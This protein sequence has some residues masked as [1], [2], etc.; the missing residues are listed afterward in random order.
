VYS[1]KAVDSRLERHLS[2]HKLHEERQSAC[3]QFHSTESALLCVQNDIL[4]SLG[5]NEATVLAMLD[6][7]AAFDTIDHKNLLC[8][9]EQHFGIV[10]LLVCTSLQWMK[11]YLCEAS[12]N[13]L[14]QRRTVK[15][16]TYDIFCATRVCSWPKDIHHVHRTCWRDLS[17]AQ[18]STSFLR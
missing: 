3:K 17:E 10:I 7:S 5:Q 15:T 16:C 6:L 9:L 14:R 1:Q 12:S 8:R 13:C 4:R 18:T 2:A 11:S